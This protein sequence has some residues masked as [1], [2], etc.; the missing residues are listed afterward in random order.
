MK[1][2][3]T[4]QCVQ[5]ARKMGR[6][7]FLRL[8]A[9]G[10]GML[11]LQACGGGTAPTAVPTA[12]TTVPT[13][14]TAVPTAPTAAPPVTA[15]GGTVTWAMLGDPVSLEPFGINMTGQYNYEA[16]E[17][18]YDSLLAWDRDLK[19]Q[20]SLA[21]SFETPDDTTYI[22][23]LRSGVKFHNGKE[24]TAE[25]SSRSIRSSTR[26][27]GTIRLL[28]SLPTLTRLRSLIR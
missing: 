19:V 6:R 12:P 5:S 24:L 17:P 26:P 15:S 13:A 18:T 21:V 3:R 4:K 2:K 14:P 11:A 27:V 10:G 25:E 7:E 8:V 23:N 16:R 22:F 1:D 20:P 9:A 28:H